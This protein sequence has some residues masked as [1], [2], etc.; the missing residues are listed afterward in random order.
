MLEVE[1]ERAPG[2]RIR[3]GRGPKTRVFG[4]MR[5]AGRAV[6]QTRFRECRGPLGANPWTVMGQDCRTL[7]WLLRPD[8]SSFPL[9]CP[10]LPEKEARE[11]ISAT[12]KTVRPFRI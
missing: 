11:G 3:A 4:V 5:E 9:S 10:W 8:H 7:A 2:I 6:G 12:V 1:R